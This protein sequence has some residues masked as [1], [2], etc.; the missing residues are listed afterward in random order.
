M[1]GVPKQLNYK[2]KIVNWFHFYVPSNQ[3]QNASKANKLKKSLNLNKYENHNFINSYLS[4]E[5]Y[6][7]LF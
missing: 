2:K 1:G 6:F 7:Y 5:N 3:I 4:L